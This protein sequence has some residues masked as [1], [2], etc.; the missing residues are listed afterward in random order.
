MENRAHYVL[1]GM[2]TLI[3]VAALLLFALWLGKVGLNKHYHHYRIVFAEAVTGLTAGSQVQ[4][5]GIRVGEVEQL[6]LDPKD[7]R[8]VLVRIEVAADTPVRTDTRAELG[9]MGFTGGALVQLTGGTP[10][11]EAL[12]PT[13]SDPVPVI[14]AKSSGMNNLLATGNR[15]AAKLDTILDRVDQVVSKQNVA[16]IDRT[17]ANIDR[18]T[19]TLA[20]EREDLRALIR[21]AASAS[22]RLDETLAKTNHLLDGPG[23]KT[24]A[25]AQRAMASLAKT[26]KTLDQLLANNREALQ[27]GLRGTD[28][29]GPTLRQMRTTLRH[30]DQLT[31]KLQD[32][33]AA[34]LLDRKR[35]AEFTPKH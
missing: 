8:K 35:P 16:H 27:S 4:Y 24:L 18:T 2:F 34:Y 9:K 30:L 3:V 7:P 19:R 11:A 17:L 10:D 26:S 5:N 31:R 32:A 13:D 33:P 15:I 12:L 29:L 21:Q 23:Q 6:R 14:R 28:Q 25:D 20:A 22:K 1:I